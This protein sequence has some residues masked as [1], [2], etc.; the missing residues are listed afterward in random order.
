MP[1]SATTPAQR[2]DRDPIAH[3]DFGLLMDSDGPS[4]LLIGSLGIRQGDLIAAMARL[5]RHA[6]TVQAGAAAMQRM[7]ERRFCLLMI[8]APLPDVTPAALCRMIRQHHDDGFRPAVMLVTPTLQPAET[9]AAYG[10]GID[11]IVDQRRFSPRVVAAKVEAL[12]RRFGY[13][14]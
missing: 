1:P 10:M 8:L 14:R 3:N 5:G 4:V 12:L 6:E 7:L 2:I 9:L 13:R 11:N